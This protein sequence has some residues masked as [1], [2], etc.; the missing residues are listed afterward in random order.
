MTW[1]DTEDNKVSDYIEK[2]ENKA[3]ELDGELAK[4]NTLRKIVGKI[5]TRTILVEIEPDEDGMRQTEAQ[6]INPKDYFGVELTDSYRLDQLSKL[7]T[8]TDEEIGD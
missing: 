5:K 6:I 3:R 4:I 2:L 1:G 7:V 8:A